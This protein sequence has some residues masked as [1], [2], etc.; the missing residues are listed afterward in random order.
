[1]PALLINIF[2]CVLMNSLK[3]LSRM[4]NIR[5]S[6]ASALRR[7]THGHGQDSA[8]AAAVTREDDG[9]SLS[10]EEHYTHALYN[11]DTSTQAMFSSQGCKA[12]LAIEIK[13][14]CVLF[15]CF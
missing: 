1:M 11:V 6:A 13:F 8:A 4:D 2:L 7:V 15:W 9:C 14:I 10:P 3:N 12:Q 5:M